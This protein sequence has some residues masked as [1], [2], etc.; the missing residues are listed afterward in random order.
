MKHSKYTESKF[1]FSRTISPL[2]VSN[3]QDYH[4]SHTAARAISVEN[5]MTKKKAP[6]EGLTHQ[7]IEA[8]KRVRPCQKR[9][10][11]TRQMLPST[12]FRSARK[13]QKHNG[14]MI[15]CLLTELGRVGREDIWFSVWTHG[16]RCATVG[17]Y[18]QTSS[19]IFS[20]LA[21]PLSQ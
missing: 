21:L 10:Y 19:Q 20:R 4:K 18:V 5:H 2:V 7:V 6:H 12:R 15:K 14:H 9:A 11:E 8:E 13:I 1:C 16:P 3:L 17:P